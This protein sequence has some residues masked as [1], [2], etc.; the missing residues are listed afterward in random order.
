VLELV[1]KQKAPFSGQGIAHDPATGGL[2]RH[3]ARQAAGRLRDAR[4]PGDFTG[5]AVADLSE[6]RIF[7]KPRA[8][9]PIGM[10]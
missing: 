2:G 3:P 8:D 5:K 1:D 4:I 9:Q 7:P 6:R 10:T